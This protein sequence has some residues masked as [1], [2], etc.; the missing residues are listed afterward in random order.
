MRRTSCRFSGAYDLRPA[1]SAVEEEAVLLPAVLD[2]VA[3]TLECALALQCHV[4]GRP[5]YLDAATAA[6]S[7]SEP[8][9]S[10]QSLASNLGEALPDLRAHIRRCISVGT[11][12]TLSRDMFVI[13]AD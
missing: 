4:D 12:I 11:P 1:L 6:S 5:A 13:L 3:S 10:L 9:P 8:Y 7:S 2:S